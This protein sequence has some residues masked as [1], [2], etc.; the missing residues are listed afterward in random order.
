LFTGIIETQAR[1]VAKE[2]EGTNTHFW[3]SSSITHELKVDQSV[4][5]NGVCLTVV[6]LNADKYRVTA[7]EETL[8]RTNLVE[9][10]LGD[11]VNL[12]RCMPSHGRFD[13][14]IVQGHVDDTAICNLVE[15]T[16]GSWRFRF[17]LNDS[18]QQKLLV[19][20]GSVCINGVSL[21]VVDCKEDWF[22]VAIIPYTFEHTNF[23]TFKVATKVNI[24]FDIVG[25]YILKHL[26][27]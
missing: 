10:E 5:H 7:I 13:G 9:L 11:K 21:T 8:G 12:E 18:K 3:F 17:K 27:K 1:L 26:D 22:S 19:Q 4:A 15:D 16:N 20:K 23:N 24:E 6:E 14:H 25:K 2:N